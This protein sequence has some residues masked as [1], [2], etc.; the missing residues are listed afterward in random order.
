MERRLWWL[1]TP[2]VDDIFGLNSQNNTWLL[3]KK[4]KKV[5]NIQIGTSFS[6]KYI[7]GVGLTKL[8][9]SWKRDLIKSIGLVVSCKIWNFLLVIHSNC[10]AHVFQGGDLCIIIEKRFH[11]TNWL[12]GFMQISIFFAYNPLKLYGPRFPKG[13]FVCNNTKATS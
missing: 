6:E 2:G 3:A 13:W 4:V 12:S 7:F 9:I 8:K 5:T 1:W 11:K 10:M